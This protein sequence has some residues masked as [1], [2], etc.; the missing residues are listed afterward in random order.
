MVFAVGHLAKGLQKGQC[1][2]CRIALG[3]L[4]GTMVSAVAKGLQRG[5]CLVGKLAL[6][7]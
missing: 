3:N 7:N 5:Q 1:L 2:V 4:A 6:G